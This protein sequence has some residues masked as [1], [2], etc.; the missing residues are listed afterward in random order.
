MLYTMSKYGDRLKA[1]RKMRGLTQ[2]ELG[3][4]AGGLT[5]SAISQLERGVSTSAT[6]EN[7]YLFAQELRINPLWLATG[8]GNMDDLQ[9]DGFDPVRLIGVQVPVIE[10]GEIE[11]TLKGAKRAR[12]SDYLIVPERIGK[13]AFALRVAGDS[14]APYFADGT[15]ITVD[16]DLTAKPGNYVIARVGVDGYLFRRLVTDGSL[17]LL[18]PVNPDYETVKV[19]KDVEIV[20]VVCNSVTRLI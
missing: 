16:P 2:S 6:V 15:F 3:A 11:L 7:N 8:K 20:G 17:Q 13:K 10:W 12:N 5:K 9:T 4:R 1:A 19:G 14:M 18:K